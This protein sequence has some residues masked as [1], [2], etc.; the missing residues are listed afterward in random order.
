MSKPVAVEDDSGFMV[1]SNIKYDGEVVTDLRDHQIK[2]IKFCESLA[3]PYLKTKYD[4]N[5]ISDVSITLGT[6]H[7]YNN[8]EIN[9]EKSTLPYGDKLIIKWI[10]NTSM[11]PQ[12]MEFNRIY[13]SKQSLT[14]EAIQAA[15]DIAY[16]TYK[17][18]GLDKALDGR[19]DS[20]SLY[21][22]DKVWKTAGQVA[23]AWAE[24][25]AP[26]SVVEEVVI[27]EAKN[28]AMEARKAMRK[29][30]WGDVVGMAKQAEAEKVAA[31][32]SAP[33]KANAVMRATALLAEAKLWGVGGGNKIR[34]RTKRKKNN[35][36]TN[37]KIIKRKKQTKK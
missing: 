20:R 3:L 7:A 13:K 37:K 24:A 30:D 26:W 23:S 17:T 21:E 34:K 16:T 33:S 27:A 5:T 2:F 32:A 29:M 35:R 6:G 15:Y 22:W 36:K 14:S 19:V 9:S 18:G 1:Y 8:I 10:S 25:K 28:G 12:Q 4:I 11:K 31:E